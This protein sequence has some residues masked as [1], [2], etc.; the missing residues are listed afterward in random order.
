MTDEAPALETADGGV[1]KV[2]PG[3]PPPADPVLSTL[4]EA[5]PAS[6]FE[7]FEPGNGPAQD[8]VIVD[9]AG[10]HDLVSAAHSER[11][12]TF[13]DL[14]G[15]DYLG[16]KPRFEVVLNVVSHPMRRRLRIRVGIPGD[17][18]TVATVSDVYP[19]AN[20]FEREAYDLFGIVFEGHPDLTR[21]LMP[22]DWEGHPLRKDYAVGSVPVQFK[23]APHA[24]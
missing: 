16:R 6:R 2:R 14:C 7:R 1:G 23:G 5:A 9:R 22:D 12:D 8:V 17:N 18:P 15:V 11:F 13:A 10:Y 20:F 21:I 4:H 19:G 3:S 24:S